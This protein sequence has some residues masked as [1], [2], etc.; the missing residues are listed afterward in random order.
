MKRTSAL[1]LLLTLAA[2]LFACAAKPAVALPNPALV[3]GEKYLLGLDYDQALL[4]FDEAIKVDPKNPRGYLGK[5]D[6]LLHLDR[7]A[8]AAATLQIGAKELKRSNPGQAQALEAARAEVEKSPEQGY[9]GLASAYETVGF[10]DVALALL[11]RVAAELPTVQEIVAAYHA[12]AERIG[13]KV[14]TAATATNPMTEPPATAAPPPTSPG[15]TQV[16]TTK[17]P[18]KAIE[19]EDYMV[20]FAGEWMRYD[21]DLDEEIACASSE[22]GAFYRLR[23]TSATNRRD[24]F[25]AGSLVWFQSSAA[26]L[27]KQ[28]GNGISVSAGSG[29]SAVNVSWTSPNIS[30]FGVKPGDS[31]SDAQSMAQRR[32]G[33]P[34]I[35]GDDLPAG[36]HAFVAV[37]NAY[38]DKDQIE[39]WICIDVK[40]NTITGITVYQGFWG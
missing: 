38:D 40:K 23:F 39:A 21:A 16:P 10:R 19:L 1:L 13:I 11:K 15:T 28:V 24:N 5:A 25:G 22:E 14:E 33:K 4:Q 18:T 34:F 31:L 9:L 36:T 37:I 12:L 7:Q 20:P 27:K 2:S 8:D 29:G 6:A 17:A 30:L 35:A 26:E 32:F 3:L